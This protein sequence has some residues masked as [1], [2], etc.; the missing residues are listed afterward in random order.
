[1]ANGSSTTYALAFVA[2]EPSSVPTMPSASI[3]LP[4][5]AMS[6]VCP[7]AMLLQPAL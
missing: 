4:L 2:E 7:V 5:L 6:A 1:M 3:Q